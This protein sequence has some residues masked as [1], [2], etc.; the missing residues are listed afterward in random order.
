MLFSDL[1]FSD[2]MIFLYVFKNFA[3][4]LDAILV[5]TG[6]EVNIRWFTNFC[7]EYISSYSQKKT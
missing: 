5:L 4:Y 1:Q 2:L 3:N 7:N 6:F